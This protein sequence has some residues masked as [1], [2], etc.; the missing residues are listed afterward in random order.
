M[1]HPLR[2]TVDDMLE[3]LKRFERDYITGEAISS[4]MD[5]HRLSAEELRPFTFWRDDYY[6][7]N[8]IFRDDKFEVMAIC[9]KPGQKTVIHSHNGALGWMTVPQGEVAVHDYKYVSCDHPERQNV[10]GIDCLA[11]GHEIELD[12][13]GSVHVHV[14]SNI[15]RV[16]K[17]HTI[18]Q[19]ENVDPSQV[20][21][22]SVHI[23]SPPID[24]CVSYDLEKHRC[25]RKT[26]KYF[27]KYGKVEIEAE[28]RADGSLKILT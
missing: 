11:G 2:T 26:L 6:T 10:V 21:V 22:V 15:Y 17:L 5:A 12:R 23:Y 20:G 8:L 18:H 9:W 24:S 7:R 1:A 16:D 4:F 14:S 27:S 13:T 19:I 25:S 3:G 28:Q